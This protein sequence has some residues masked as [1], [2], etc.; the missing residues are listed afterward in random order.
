MFHDVDDN[1]RD[2]DRDERDDGSSDNAAARKYLPSGRESNFPDKISLNPL[3]V[4]SNCT[5]R[6]PDDD[7]DDSDDDDSDYDDNYNQ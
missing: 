3:M 7:D 2:D 6:P 4:S 1:D 5:K